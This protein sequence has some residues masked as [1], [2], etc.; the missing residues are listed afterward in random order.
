M[1]RRKAFSVSLS[2]AAVALTSCSGLPKG[3]S[4]GGGGGKS[5]VSFALVADTLPAN[6]SILSFR[7]TINGVQIKPA[8]GSALTLTPV[9]PVIDLMRL[10]SD[11][12][13]LGSLSQVPAGSYTLQASLANPIL[14][15]LNDTGSTLTAG[16]TT[17]S[18]G[19]VCT[20]ALTATGNPTIGS[21][22]LTVAASTNQGVELDFN[23]NS[24][25]S[26]SAG[27]LSVTFSPASP[28]P[29]VLSAFTL[30]RQNANL[31]SNQLELIED[32]SGV[33][34][35]SSNNVTL[36]SPARGALTSA[37]GST[38]FFDPSPDGTLCQT[39]A[40][41]SCVVNGQVGSVDAF[42][43]VDG[44]LS[45]KEYEPLTSTQQDLV[46]GTVYSI[47]PA[48]GTQFG[49]VVTD[50]IEAATG[51]LIG[52]LDVGDLL[53]VNIP[54]PKPFFVDTK[55]LPVSSFAPGTFGNFS[56]Q[57]STS[58]IHQGQSILVHVTAFT[59]ASGT[60]IASATADTVT[61]RWSRLS[62]SVQAASSPTFTI[63][64][65]PSYFG[66]AQG[67]LFGVQAFTGTA[68]GDGI[69]NFDGI[70]AANNLTPSTPP[71]EL[72]AL[73]LEN[74]TNSANPVFFA[75][76]VRQH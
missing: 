42:L 30:P 71:V 27:I 73:F 63:I 62:S 21:F 29:G 6:P 76:K 69:T 26:L 68:G 22:T 46:E 47:T 70:A 20:A 32:F 53:T 24:A 3:S 67:S 31:G 18:S 12:A 5:T 66:F 51:S 8:T 40:S 28:T 60:T 54:S 74:T 64:G 4:G 38:S 17:C 57:T 55:G 11:T 7:V 33:V 58:A 16:S 45:L 36:T 25:I 44:S 14:T 49:I 35:V 9:T 50:R 34:S 61:L 43:N 56:G 75:A 65:L 15:F 19:S 37:N 59:A 23:L 41:F 10:Q 52:G 48:S 2:L 72:R 39:P 13:F 1:N